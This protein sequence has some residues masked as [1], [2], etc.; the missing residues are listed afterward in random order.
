VRDGITYQHVLV[1]RIPGIADGPPA[2]DRDPGTAEYTAP[3]LRI[4][5]PIAPFEA[6]EGT[7]ENDRARGLRRFF[8]PIVSPVYAPPPLRAPGTPEARPEPTVEVARYLSVTL[9]GESDAGVVLALPAYESLGRLA[10]RREWDAGEPL[11]EWGA[12][13]RAQ[14]PEPILPT[15][16]AHLGPLYDAAWEMLWDRVR[17]PRPESGLPGPYIS[18]GPGFPHHQFV[19]DTALTTVAARYGHAHLPVAASLDLLYSRLFDGGYLHREHDTR[20]GSPALYEPDFSPNPP[21]LSVAEWNLAAITG[22]IHRLSAVYPALCEIHTWLRVNRR[23]P[24]GTYWTTGLA[25]GLDNSPSLGDGYPDLTAQMAH[26]AETLA[27]IAD[28]LGKAEDKQ[29]WLTELR[30]IGEAL[31]R[32]LWN[33]EQGIYATSLGD[34]GHNPTKV[35]T[36]FWPLWAGIVPPERAERLAR[37]LRDPSSFGRHCPL[38]SLAAD[39]PAFVPGGDYWRGSVWAPTSYAALSGFA[40]AGYRDPARAA[41]QR[42]LQVLY[43][44]WSD[45]GKLW[46]NYSSE[47]PSRRGSTSQ[48]D[49]CWTAL[50]PIALLLEILLGFEVDAVSGTVRWHIP[51]SPRGEGSIGVRRLPVGSARVSAV[52]N[53]DGSLTLDT[54]AEIFIELIGNGYDQALHLGAGRLEVPP[55]AT[56]GGTE[57]QRNSANEE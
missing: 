36:A 57:I 53:P 1:R 34:G 33:E 27:R 31:N 48:P 45:T 43:D 25:N 7:D 6:I 35:V 39:S 20:D 40:R 24:D 21:L 55:P 13:A 19:W 16:L 18:T 32:Y 56:G 4:T 2:S 10:P 30:E 47:A 23:L 3:A 38:P 46:E 49:Y 26:D 50:G 5:S 17:T 9:Q 54:D 44:V 28:V 12:E 37:H 14:L 51:P 52:R 8:V 22:D 29:A 42:F 41:T 15:S 11:R